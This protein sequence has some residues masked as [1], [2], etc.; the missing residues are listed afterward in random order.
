MLGNA[1]PSIVPYLLLGFVLPLLTLV[2]TFYKYKGAGETTPTFANTGTWCWLNKDTT[3]LWLYDF[4]GGYRFLLFY[5]PTWLM[6]IFNLSTYII[7]SRNILSAYATRNRALPPAVSKMIRRMNR[8]PLIL[9]VCIFPA[10]YNRLQQWIDPHHN[11]RNVG[12]YF[13]HLT[14]HLMGFLNL[15]A[16]AYTPGVM[17]EWSRHILTTPS[18]SSLVPLLK[19]FSPQHIPRE[20][21]PN[22]R[23]SK[24]DEPDEPD[25][26]LSP[27]LLKKVRQ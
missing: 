6:I 1:S 7:I 13:L 16:Y 21:N 9:A 2:P 14:L 27:V 3:L 22:P 11:Q 26:V 8:Y 25:T 12:L 24:E 17:G 10:S 20:S 4:H 15:I 23:E 18:L 19:R 5:L